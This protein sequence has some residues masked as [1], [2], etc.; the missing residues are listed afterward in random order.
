MSW[1]R[2][3]RQAAFAADSGLTILV[4][5]REIHISWG[6]VARITAFKRDLVT[7]DLICIEFVDADGRV[8]EVNEEVDGYQAVEDALVNRF[9][10]EKDW[11]RHIALPAFQENRRVLYEGPASM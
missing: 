9:H 8:Y 7:S 5:G 6:D 2:R 1:F 11:R 10:V 3:R 4:Q